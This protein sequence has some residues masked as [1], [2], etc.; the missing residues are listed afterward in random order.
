MAKEFN[1]SAT[2]RERLLASTGNTPE[3]KSAAT[4]LAA[5]F[6]QSI[7]DCAV[8]L[9]HLGLK[10]EDGGADIARALERGL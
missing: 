6:A 1:L 3:E 8:L 5:T 9:E 10:P 7:E 4:Q 2:E